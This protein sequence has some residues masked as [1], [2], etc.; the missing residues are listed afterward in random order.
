MYFYEL[1]RLKEDD[2]NSFVGKIQEAEYC[3][4]VGQWYIATA[5]DDDYLSKGEKWLRRAI[6][7]G[8]AE[9]KLH[10]ANMYRLGDLGK[11]DMDEY[12]RLLHESMDEGCQL[13][14]IRFCKDI[15]YGVGQSAD[16]DKGLDEAQRRLS[17][18]PKPDPRWYDTIGWMMFAKDDKDKANELFLKAIGCGFA[19][20]YF[21]LTGMLDKQE[22]GR[23]AGCGGSCIL[24][25]EELEKKYDENGLT[26]ANAVECFSD[27]EQKRA[28]LDANYKYREGLAAQ[29]EALFK[30]AVTLG[31]PM[32]LY[33]Q[34]GLYYSALY[35]HL[36]DDDKAWECY[37]RGNQ[38]GDMGCMS[39][40]AEMIEEG[41][42][43]DGFGWEEAC[44]FRL[45]ALR[46]GDDDQLLPV[47][48]AYFE[49]GLED[50][51]D[52]IERYYKPQFDALDL[53]SDDSDV[54]DDPE[55]DDG[56]YDAWA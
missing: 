27:D 18:H 25:A 26:D 32:G 41:R 12:Q 36:E 19:D 24:L 39:M 40:L 48:A 33:L 55:D 43:P 8:D 42:A 6:S 29:I 17:A 51:K 20:S 2:L 50:Y 31:E 11:V 53:E 37:M 5:P 54:D 34:G 52:E 23:K 9:A 49:G 15:A 30:E 21:G 44:F 47:M 13:A 10:L 16:L 45:K 28:Y 46:Y 3:R 38:L 56:R 35:H 22:E 7:S 1:F 4:L 14:E